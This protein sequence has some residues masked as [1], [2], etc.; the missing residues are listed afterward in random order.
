M[1]RLNLNPNL[2]EEEV[3]FG[4]TDP[5]ACNYDPD[6][7]DN[8]GCFYYEEEGWCSCEGGNS[9][10]TNPYSCE[11]DEMADCDNGMCEGG[12]WSCGYNG[13]FVTSFTKMDYGSNVD[14]IHGDIYITRGDNQG[15]YNPNYCLLYTSPSPRDVEESRMPSSA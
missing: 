10:C 3:I 8:E 6:A 2:N 5:S 15:I 1:I 13:G 4:C 11:Y 7:N 12:N 9:G 14:Y